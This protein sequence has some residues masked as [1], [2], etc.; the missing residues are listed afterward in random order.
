MSYLTMPSR[1]E[2]EKLS[3]RAMLTYAAKCARRMQPMYDA[4]P[5]VPNRHELIAAIDQAITV[6]EQYLTGGVQLPPH[7]YHDRF[8]Y[9]NEVKKFVGKVAETTRVTAE[10]AS[11]TAMDAAAIASLLVKGIAAILNVTVEEDPNAASIY[12]DAIMSNSWDGAQDIVARE[13][14]HTRAARETDAQAIRMAL[15]IETTSEIMRIAS[16]HIEADLLIS[17]Y[18]LVMK[19]LQN[20]EA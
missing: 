11:G 14:K 10:A 19:H 3:I 13:T 15:A 17:D 16:L 20:Q 12:N 2:L 6:S 18:E 7:Q 8:D 4:P 9:G 1:Q 5:N